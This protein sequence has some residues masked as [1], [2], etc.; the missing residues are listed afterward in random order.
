M[1]SP[2]WRALNAK[3]RTHKLRRW[4]ELIIENQDCLARLM[5]LKQGKPLAEAKGEIV[6]ASS[7]IEWFTEEATPLTVTLYGGHQ[8][9]KRLIMIKPPVGVNVVITP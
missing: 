2:A 5:P 1:N 8:Q 7:F 9:D 3:A 6:Y 4:F